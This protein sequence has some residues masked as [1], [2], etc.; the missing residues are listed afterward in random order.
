MRN[1]TYTG[2]R[3]L[4]RPIEKSGCVSDSRYTRLDIRPLQRCYHNIEYSYLQTVEKNTLERI[5]VQD[6][7]YSFLIFYRHH[8]YITRLLNS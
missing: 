3:K 4:S 6:D 5:S 2:Q 1:K 7:M 8:E